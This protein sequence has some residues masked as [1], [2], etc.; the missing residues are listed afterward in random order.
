M[1]A[2]VG[3]LLLQSGIHLLVKAGQVDLPIGELLV[4]VSLELLAVSL[5]DLQR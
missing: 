1:P 5:I 2:V 4:L 3:H